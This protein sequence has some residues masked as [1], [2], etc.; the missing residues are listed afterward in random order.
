MDNASVFGDFEVT[1][2]YCFI[3]L[4]HFQIRCVASTVVLTQLQAYPVIS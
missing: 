1:T 3:V 2:L 4:M